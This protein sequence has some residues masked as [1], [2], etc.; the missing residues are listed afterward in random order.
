MRRVQNPWLNYANSRSGRQLQ[1]MDCVY[2]PYLLNPLKDFHYTFIKC[3]PQ[4]ECVQNTYSDV[5]K[6]CLIKKQT[7]ISLRMIRPKLWFFFVV[8]FF[9]QGKSIQIALKAGHQWWPK[10]ECWLSSF[11]IFSGSGPVLLRNPILLYFSGGGWSGPP[12]PPLDPRMSHEILVFRH[13]RKGLLHTWLY[14]HL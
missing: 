6:K 13:I 8:C 9:D 7:W 14:D 11:V 2:A 3:S 10:I 1:V 5:K 12:V 4:C